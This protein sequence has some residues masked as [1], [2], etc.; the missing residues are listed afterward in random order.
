MAQA[1]EALRLAQAR[2]DAGLSGILELTQAQFA[3]TSAQIGA[4]SARF[5]YLQRRAALDYEMGALR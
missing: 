4:A 3:Q 2:Y 1:S 5:E